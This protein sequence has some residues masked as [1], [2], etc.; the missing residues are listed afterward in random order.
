MP[1][2]PER[3]RPAFQFK[4]KAFERVNPTP[5][6]AHASPSGAPPDARALARLAAQSGPRREVAPRE[7]DVH[8]IL[9]ENHAVATAHGLN[10]VAPPPRRRSRRRRDYLAGMILV[11]L[12]FAAFGVL[13]WVLALAGIVLFSCGYTWVIWFVM[14][15]Y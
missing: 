14:D 6:E 10:E 13:N 1:D 9:R 11:N 4:P 12:V 3:S 5:G 15:D 7:N 2:E 8:R